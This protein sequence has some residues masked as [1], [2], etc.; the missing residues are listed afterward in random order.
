MNDF[1]ANAA[2]VAP[3]IG[4][5]VTL[6]LIWPRAD[7]RARTEKNSPHR[8][9]EE[10][11]DF[12]THL[13]IDLTAG[14]RPV[15][16]TDF[17]LVW[18]SRWRPAYGKISRNALGAAQKFPLKIEPHNFTTLSAELAGPGLGGVMRSRAPSRET[19]RAVVL[20]CSPP[21]RFF[22]SNCLTLK[23]AWFDR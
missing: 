6:W 7:I 10:R 9:P 18:W 15:V 14:Q 2:K 16:V 23:R 19:F 4:L 17:W 1:L 21:R 3:V 11:R 13:I 5:F 8:V 20:A 22:R 12:P